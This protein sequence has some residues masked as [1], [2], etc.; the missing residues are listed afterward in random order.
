MSTS[1]PVVKVNLKKQN[2]KPLIF[3]W[4]I[5]AQLFSFMTLPGP[6]GFHL[7]LKAQTTAKSLFNL[8]LTSRIFFCPVVFLPRAPPDW[9]ARRLL[10][11]PTVIYTHHLLLG[12]TD[13]IFPSTFPFSDKG[14]AL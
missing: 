7:V 2:K 11:F 9:N 6:V 1:I 13:R 3:T 12:P 14:A 10:H 4:N 5:Q 8:L